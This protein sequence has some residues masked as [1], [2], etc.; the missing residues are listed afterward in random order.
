MREILNPSDA[1]S[2]ENG[3]AE[4]DN[5]FYSKILFDTNRNGNDLNENKGNLYLHYLTS[6]LKLLFSNS[7]SVCGIRGSSKGIL[8][9]GDTSI[10][11]MASFTW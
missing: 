4:Q 8:S 7:L 10:F 3:A 2:I 5:I 9:S 11:V 1:L 6:N